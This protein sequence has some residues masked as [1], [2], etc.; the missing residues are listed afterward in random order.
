MPPKKS[1]K[2]IGEI[3]YQR[4]VDAAF[5]ANRL[6]YIHKFYG[7]QLYAKIIMNIIDWI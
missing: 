5:E 1:M 6:N 4:G 2:V 7:N 3:A